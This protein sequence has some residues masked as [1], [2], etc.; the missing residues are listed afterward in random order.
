MWNPICRSSS[1]KA[2]GSSQIFATSAE[3]LLY[4]VLWNLRQATQS[5]MARL[6]N[7]VRSASGQSET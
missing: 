2:G 6:K 4:L 3:I 1:N 7:I 5:L